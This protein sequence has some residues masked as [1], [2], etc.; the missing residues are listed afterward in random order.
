MLSELAE[1]VKRQFSQFLPRFF[2]SSCWCSP[3]AEAWVGGRGPVARKCARSDAIPAY[4]GPKEADAEY[5]PAFK[6]PWKRAV[7]IK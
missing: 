2:P 1:G 3:N 4:A 7:L 5:K 6:V